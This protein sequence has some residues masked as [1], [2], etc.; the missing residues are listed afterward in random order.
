MRFISR[1]VFE[2]ILK[3]EKANVTEFQSVVKRLCEYLN[4]LLSSD[5]LDENIIT[6]RVMLTE[7]KFCATW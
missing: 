4:E 3:I 7:Q 6:N 1:G 2:E 5:I